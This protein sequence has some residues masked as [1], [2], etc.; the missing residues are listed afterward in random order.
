VRSADETFIIVVPA[1]RWLG[2]CVILDTSFYNIL[3]KHETV[4]ASDTS[5]FSSL[6]HFLRKPFL[7]IYLFLCIN[8]VI[9]S[10]NNDNNNNGIINN[11]YGRP[12][13]YC[14]LKNSLQNSKDYCSSI[15]LPSAIYRHKVRRT[16]SG[17]ISRFEIV[18]FKTNTFFHNFQSSRLT[19][20]SDV[21]KCYAVI[22]S[23]TRILKN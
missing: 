4:V 13:I 10:N 6:S 5:K 22:R 19:E 12:R 14:A 18:Y 16:N 1:E 2:E 9:I 8:Y 7:E 17:A 3:S 15:Y 11:I 23:H 20:M 21:A